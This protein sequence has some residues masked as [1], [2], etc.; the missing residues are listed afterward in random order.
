MRT[1]V[2]RLPGYTIIEWNEDNYS[3][4]HPFFEQ[5]C[6]EQQF[7]FASDIARLDILYRHGGIYLDTDVEIKKNLDGFLRARMFMGLE[8]DCFLGT[9]LIGAVAGHPLLKGLLGEY[10]N[11]AA[12]RY[13]VN[14]GI[15]TRYLLRHYPEFRLV[16]R[17]QTLTGGI[18]IYPKECFVMPPLFSAGGYARHHAV[19]SWQDKCQRPMVK[20]VANFLLGDALYLHLAHHKSIRA[21]EFYRIYRQH[22]PSIFGC[23]SSKG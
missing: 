19:N 21:N 17:K 12:G 3:S 9:S 18:D 1:W 16:N 20:R 8:A 6:R 23:K 2:E 15:L 7:S 14:N 22:N 13:V 11:L 4:V 5:A 10:D